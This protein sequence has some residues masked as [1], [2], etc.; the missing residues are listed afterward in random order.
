MKPTYEILPS[1]DHLIPA[2]KGIDTVVL[3]DSNLEDAVALIQRAFQENYLQLQ[4]LADHLKDD[5][6]MQS[7]FNIYHWIVNNLPYKLD[8]SRKEQ[9]R[10][11]ARAWQDRSRGVD[12]EDYTVFVSSL[13]ANMGYR[14]KAEVVAFN[15]KPFYQH[16]YPVVFGGD[17]EIIIDPTPNP[18]QGPVPFNKR[19]EG[20]TKKF[21]VNMELQYLQGLPVPETE[22]MDMVGIAGF[23][24]I[25]QPGTFTRS[26]INAR[27]RLI[28]D[29]MLKPDPNVAK[30]IRKL[31]FM[32]N[33]N[34]VEEQDTFV[35]V[36]PFMDDITPIGQIVWKKDVDL[37]ALGELIAVNEAWQQTNY[38]P[39]ITIITFYLYISKDPR[40]NK[41]GPY[42]WSEGGVSQLSGLPQGSGLNVSL[43]D[44][45]GIYDRKAEQENIYHQRM[46]QLAGQENEL[47]LQKV[48]QENDLRKKEEELKRKEEELQKLKEIYESHSERVRRGV[49]MASIKIFEDFFGKKELPGLGATAAIEEPSSP[50]EQAVEAL[51]A[52][53]YENTSAKEEVAAI[54]QIVKNIIDRGSYKEILR[55]AQKNNSNNMSGAGSEQNGG[56]ANFESNS[57]LA[58]EFNHERTS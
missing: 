28:Q 14:C 42:V 49:E 41:R 43:G 13:A 16:I 17:F 54:H 22:E 30:G 12:C 1:Y 20:I 6:A 38:D 50:H 26:C 9:V 58:K 47:R 33:L 34:G 11:P 3:R 53:V 35:I 23:G 51:A 21:N 27:K 10:T 7:S 48:L 19:P 45:Q 46:I 31:H 52:T 25:S 5:T 15:N 56:G 32:T 24:A 39:E 36:Y 8:E 29:Y 57:N 18:G 44:L 40:A 4:R 37:E 2:A 55:S